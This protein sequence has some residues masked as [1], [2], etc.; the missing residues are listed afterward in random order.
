MIM[1]FKN[2]EHA[3]EWL[4]K[5]KDSAVEYSHCFNIIR[6]T[7]FGEG[8]DDNKQINPH[9][10]PVIERI[11]NELVFSCNDAIKLKYKD[12]YREETQVFTYLDEEQ[13]QKQIDEH[14]SSKLNIPDVSIEPFDE[15]TELSYSGDDY[16][17]ES[18][19]VE[20]NIQEVIEIDQEIE[21]VIAEEETASEKLSKITEQRE[22]NT[23]GTI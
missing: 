9:V 17:L 3:Q 19:E 23:D 11:T 2:T 4:T 7:I 21:S 15:P 8:F 6:D 5:F 22:E 1:D 20:N 13:L 16:V 10:V 14:L 12:D 18:E